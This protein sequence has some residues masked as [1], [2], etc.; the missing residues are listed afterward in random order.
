MSVH[1]LPVLLK[2]TTALGIVSALGRW[3]LL[4]LAALAGLFVAGVLID[5][6]WALPPS[7]RIAVLV[8][9]GAAMVG[10]ALY[11][12][13]DVGRRWMSPR[14]A[15]RAI[16]KRLKIQD[17]R[18]INAIDL[19]ERPSDAASRV[20]TAKAIQTGEAT[21]AETSSLAAIDFR[22]LLKSLTAAGIAAFVLAAFWIGAP[23][24]LA[25]VLP[26]YWD[27][28]GDHPPYTLL[29]FE[30][31]TAPERV[32]VDQPA[33]ISA[34][35]RGPERITEAD[36]VEVDAA[37]RPL[38]RLS[39]I[40]AAEGRF[41]LPLSRVEE[42]LSFHIETARGR[43][44]RHR[45]EVEDSPLLEEVFAK[46]EHPAYA[47]WQPTERAAVDRP[48]RLLQG[49]T[50]TLSA[51]ASRPL[52]SGKCELTAE[53]S[54]RA[55]TI[56]DLVPDPAE[57]RR[58]VGR[59]IV[60]GSARLR[61]TATGVNGAASR[62]DVRGRIIAI[63]DQPPRV[64]IL[65]PTSPL[66]VA[67]DYRVPVV[68]QAVDDVGI[69]RIELRASINGFGPT[70]VDLRVEKSG[71]IVAVGR[72]AFDLKELGARPGD[73]IT[74]RAIAW[75]RSPP[76]GNFS[77]TELAVIRVLSNEEYRDQ[78]LADYTMDELVRE[79]E[80]MQQNLDQLRRQETAE[81]EELE[82]LRKRLKDGAPPSD[83]ER[84]Q[85]EEI[86]ER[87]QKLAE[88]AKR[89]ARKLEER[90]AQQPLHE[91][92]RQMLETLKSLA[93]RLEKRAED[94]EQVADDLQRLLKTPD[95]ETLKKQ[96]DDAIAR[97]EKGPTAVENEA[98]ERLHQ[99]MNRL[100]DIDH[101]RQQGEKLQD[102]AEKQRDLADRLGEF[103]NRD[104]LKP[105]E[106]P[107]AER[108]AGEQDRL[109]QE[110][111]ET[112]KELADAAEKCEGAAP[113]TASDAKKIAESLKELKVDEDQR[114]AAE[115]ARQGNGRRSHGS[116]ESAAKKL[117]SL[118]EGDDDA[119]KTA[120][121]MTGPD[122]GMRL[123]KNQIAQTLKR[124][125]QSRQLPSLTG[126]DGP[127]DEKPQEPQGNRKGGEGSGRQGSR[128]R[129]TVMGPHQ[130]MEGASKPRSGHLGRDGLDVH[131][132]DAMTIGADGSESLTPR[133]RTARRG[134]SGVLRGVPAP[135]RDQ[136]E[137]YFRRISEGK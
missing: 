101:L 58:V 14:A 50:I 43:S 116:A 30:I 62:N 108:M 27:P 10:I 134:T 3:T 74:Y 89:E 83:A 24:L 73:L 104:Q 86:Q 36:L 40:A 67:E 76:S 34:T 19:A 91:A 31:T 11:A 5:A 128:S 26:R 118:A 126:L 16:E 60:N 72:T 113:R 56:V 39:M 127:S 112:A 21:A 33:E 52:Q 92:E 46:L 106:Q 13:R 59:W 110:L 64:S 47:E 82:T 17:N 65:Q 20:L 57:P 123:T 96:L 107:R 22:P 90:A 129:A 44:R 135:F 114:T 80:G 63:D 79:L 130:P 12:F 97:L 75:D 109:E 84:R 25:A 95:N 102:L 9:G 8:L 115:A 1:H 54:G 131:P 98:Q 35:I 29:D 78:A 68:I 42:S 81:R 28:H 111:K 117:E 122:S 85:W 132:D 7:G 49:T 45:L 94:V 133:E 55:A 105:E 2:R 37:G 23:R 103:R 6:A 38:R 120:G 119:E 71:A 4:S 93:E 100:R 124:L 48:L 121:G 99:E 70:P 18:L 15:A 53:S 41:T 69:D 87:L 77:E 136:A 125:T 66:L 32:L 61:I 51:V 88:A 137:A